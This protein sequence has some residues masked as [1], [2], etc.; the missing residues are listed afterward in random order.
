MPKPFLVE[1]ALEIAI[2]V[3]L[4]GAL[5]SVVSI[6]DLTVVSLGLGDWAYWTIVIGLIVF[7]AGIFL[8]AGYLKLSS[9]FD[10]Y[11]KT[12]SRAEFK[13]D[14]DE[15]EYLAWRLPSR[16]GKRLADKKEELGLK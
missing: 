6:V 11:M 4:V 5:L 16:F 8:L 3:T 12:A 2:T 13:K 10:R 1:H 15:V 7:I 14:Q 9:Q